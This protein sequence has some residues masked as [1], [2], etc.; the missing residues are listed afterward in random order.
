MG[1]HFRGEAIE[2]GATCGAR[3]RRRG[4]PAA[5]LATRD[6]PCG[7]GRLRYAHAP[8]GRK[9]RSFA[10]RSQ[11][12]RSRSGN[13]ARIFPNEPSARPPPRPCT[14]TQLFRAQVRRTDRIAGKPP[15]RARSTR[16]PQLALRYHIHSR[17]NSARAG[18]ARAIRIRDR[19]AGEHPRKSHRRR[20][21]SSAL[22][23]S[24]S[25]RRGKLAGPCR[26]ATRRKRV[27]P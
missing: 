27:G 26:S 3:E 2:I 11:Q 16:S 25:R 6:T 19:L 10:G 4:F 9:A 17:E 22:H 1:V 23:R 18:R 7:A 13:P 21:P 8:C 5:S 15:K 24:R 14:L 20:K 12:R